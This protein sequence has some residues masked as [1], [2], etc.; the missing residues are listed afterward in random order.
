MNNNYLYLLLLAA[1][2]I[3][4]SIQPESN[5]VVKNSIIETIEQQSADMAMKAEVLNVLLAKAQSLDCEKSVHQCK[6]IKRTL[7]SLMIG[8]VLLSTIEALFENPTERLEK[9][10][11]D[12]TQESQN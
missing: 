1:P 11:S 12:L 5:D 6:A 9:F 4:Y 8:D 2:V 3:V 7:Q 10:F